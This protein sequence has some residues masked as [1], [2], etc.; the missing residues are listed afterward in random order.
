MV[1][2]AHERP[3]DAAATLVHEVVHSV[4]GLGANHGKHFKAVAT[5][6]GLE[7]KMDSTHAGAALTNRLHG[8]IESHCGGYP[9]A[10]LGSTVRFRGPLDGPDGGGDG[11]D[12]SGPRAQVCRQVLITCTECDVKLR[13]ARGIGKGKDQPTGI[14]ALLPSPAETFPCPCGGEFRPD[15]PEQVWPEINYLLAFLAL[16]GAPGLEWKASSK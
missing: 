4:V 3:I 9:G 8:L 1:S 13:G 15:K 5:A 11:P 7:G 14:R 10:P 16:A 2:Y 6:I 12:S